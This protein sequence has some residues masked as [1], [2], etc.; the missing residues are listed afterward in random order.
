MAMNKAK[1]AALHLKAMRD[2]DRLYSVDKYHRL[3]MNEDTVVANV[4]GGTWVDGSLDNNSYIDGGGYRDEEDSPRFSSN[5]IAY[6]LQKSFGTYLAMRSELDIKPDGQG[7][8][9]EG[10]ELLD[11]II[12]HIE[13]QSDANNAYDA[14]FSSNQ[15]CGF[16]AWCIKTE[17]KD[18]GFDQEVWI[19]AI[20]DAA[21]TLFFDALST[22]QILN[23]DAQ[24]LFYIEHMSHDEHKKRWKGAEVSSFNSIA[25]L[26]E[27]TTMA[28]SWYT[29]DT[30]A[31]AKYW[32]KEKKSK[33]IAQLKDGT[34]IDVESRDHEQELIRDG[35]VEVYGDGTPKIRNTQVDVVKM[36]MMNGLE[37]LEGAYD[38]PSQYFPYIPSYGVIT[39]V[40]GTNY[41]RGR[42]RLAKDMQRAHDFA[43]S[44]QIETT[45]ITPEQPI[46]FFD[47]QIDGNE[48]D[49]E[50]Q[51]LPPVLK[52]N[53]EEGMP[54]PYRMAPA[55]SDVALIQ[56]VQ[57]SQAGVQSAMGVVSDQALQQISGKSYREQV[58]QT[59][60]GTSVNRENQR[61]AKALTGTI[62]I[63]IIPNVFT[64]NSMINYVDVEGS[65]QEVEINKPSRDRNTADQTLMNDVSV[66]SYKADAVAS[67]AKSSQNAELS[68]SLSMMTVNNPELA[69]VT[70]D[71]QAEL[72]DA[73][74]H[75]KRKL[76]KRV[77]TYMIQNGTYQPTPEEAEELGVDVNAIQQQRAA[78]ERANKTY[79]ESQTALNNSL[80]FKNT[81]AGHKTA[82]ETDYKVTDNQYRMIEIRYKE[83]ESIKLK[84]ET[85]IPITEND[86][87]I[88]Q[89]SSEILLD[90]FSDSFEERQQLTAQLQNAMM[91]MQSQATSQAQQPA[92][93]NAQQNVQAIQMQD[94]GLV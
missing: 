21:N 5:L 56:Q 87:L 78:T 33:K 88:A 67:I 27:G 71:I 60:L 86:L 36:V 65:A 45:A 25:D 40:Q 26:S 89:L 30:V 82:A 20:P 46:I 85:G 58:T 4:Q 74:L 76:E 92:A 29:N 57:M 62:L 16:G 66:G 11:A 35:V 9:K 48:S 6:E 32:Y 73:P 24:H 13:G 54:P 90:D 14:G 19:D 41:I 44:K 28:S 75:I 72:L 59:N 10:A 94:A 3:L 17:F 77:K 81:E 69:A 53:W 52:A 38:F 18:N 91:T 61:K 15:T 22:P 64:Y 34:V 23:T 68:E 31:V 1:R 83:L 2:W 7:A 51:P 47:G 70:A 39:T 37:I 8:T 49:W 42:V 93:P 43:L 63:D 12:K 79:L 55:H 84:L 80:I 50:K